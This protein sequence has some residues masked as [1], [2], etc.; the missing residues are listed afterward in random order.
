M[1]ARPE[2]SRRWYLPFV[3]VLGAAAIF[4]FW[5]Y[6]SDQDGD[7]VAAY[8]GTYVEASVGAPQRINPLYARLNPADADLVSLVFSGLTRLGPDGRVLPDLAE[9][10]EINEDG[11]EYTFRLRNGSVWHDGEDVTADDV[12]F[13]W[14]V[15]A[16]EDFDADPD[17]SDFWQ[18][19]S[20]E[21]VDDLTV[22]FTLDEPFAPFLAQTT[23]GI[24]PEH[25]LAG[26]PVAELAQSSFN[27]E[28]VGTGPYRLESLGTRSASLRS[29]D[30]F[31]LGP[32]YVE[33]IRLD[34][35][36]NSEA[37]VAAVRAGEADGVY[38]PEVIGRDQRTALEA[39]H[40]VEE[41]SSNSYTMLY[42]NWQLPAFQDETVRRAITLAIDRRAIVDDI[43][44]GRGVIADT[45][46]TPATWASSEA[47]E[48]YA[49]DP[50]RAE[51]LLAD[52]GWVPGPTGIRSR[53]DIELSF[54]LITNNDSTRTA[55]A[56]QIAQD[57]QQVGIGVSFSS[58]GSA[59]LYE[60]VLQP[61]QFEMALFG[62]T[63]GADPDPFPAWHSS[64]ADGG[65][66]IAAF[67]DPVVDD[68]LAQARVSAD[69]DRRA[70]LYLHFQQT[71]YDIQPSLALFYPTNLYVLPSD[72]HGVETGVAFSPASRFH[73]VWEWYLE[74]E[75]V[76]DE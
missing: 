61:H 43:L 32:P 20:A 24:L 33:Q 70:E 13:T 25:L 44:A 74:T 51:A 14:S 56:A 23:I 63:A 3:L 55:I 48:P 45:V 37:A 47:L 11:S 76:S 6:A 16:S 64:Q 27:Q 75:T 7:E 19:V 39:D 22:R 62:F 5:I 49:Y 40:T 71:F 53:G 59:T 54:D 67:A 57:L 36:A 9:R 31:H 73:N 46:I 10:W 66:N 15:L 60:Q 68:T 38:L 26:V 21:R 65:A 1:T 42:L 30:A 28:P 12:V 35:Y 2:L 34:Y 18:S 58:S 17:L 50:E 52:A 41:L 8:G 69:R 29:N 4:A 72:L